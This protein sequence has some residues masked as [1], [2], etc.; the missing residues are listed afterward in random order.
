MEKRNEIPAA[1]VL[2]LTDLVTIQSRAVVSRTLMEQKTGTLTLFAFDQEQGLSEHTAPFDAFV[3]VLAGE[4][5]I[6]I[7][8]I[9]FRLVEGQAVLMPAHQPH[10]LRAVSPLKMLLFM[11]RS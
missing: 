1:E 3:Q 11:V 7:A 4:V 10:A 5:E 9:P 6:T 8:G 2:S